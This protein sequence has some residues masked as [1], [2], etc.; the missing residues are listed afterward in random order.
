[1]FATF[2]EYLV[3]QGILSEHEY[4]QLMSQ[5][6]QAVVPLSSL[7]IQRRMMTIK[8]VAEV[9]DYLETNPKRDF[10]SVAVQMDYLDSVDA[11]TLSQV[12][13][14][15]SPGLDQILV[16]MQRMTAQQADVLREHFARLQAATE[17]SAQKITPVKPPA[18]KFHQR[19][20]RVVGMVGR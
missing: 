2:G 8:Q 15:Q 4:R 10:L 16:T 3:Q 18:P 1:M 9:L 11:K 20:I 17:N 14:Q 6:A 13:E 19:A 5:H 12:Q 7:A